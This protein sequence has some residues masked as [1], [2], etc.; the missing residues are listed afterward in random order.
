MRDSSTPEQFDDQL[1]NLVSRCQQSYQAWSTASNVAQQEALRRIYQTDLEH[2]W[3]VLA[4]AFQRAAR[5][6]LGSGMASD[7]ESMAQ[8]M[9]A[10]IIFV[11][12]RLKVDPNQD[13]L[14]YLIQTARN[15]TVDEY[16]QV[17]TDRRRRARKQATDD[18][19]C[20]R[21]RRFR[22]LCPCLRRY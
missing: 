22:R 3:D 20:P 9:F 21:P 10:H 17:Y 8:G 18:E 13:V 19:H 5:G 16:R 11:L 7:I 14:S 2:L 12:P 15:C 4:P 1:F 6:W